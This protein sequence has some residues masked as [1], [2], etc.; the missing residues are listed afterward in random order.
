VVGKMAKIKIIVNN[1]ETKIDYIGFS[2][3]QCDVAEQLILRNLRLNGAN[4]AVTKR[5]NKPEY[6]QAERNENK[7]LSL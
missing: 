5:Q 6:Y 3:K 4:I 7:D 1:A 2:G